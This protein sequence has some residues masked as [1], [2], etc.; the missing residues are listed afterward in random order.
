ME[1][2]AITSAEPKE[3][4]MIAKYL[5]SH[6]VIIDTEFKST[7]VLKETQAHKRRELISDVEY[8]YALALNHGDHY[9]GQAEIRF[10]V[11]QLPSDDNELFLDCAALAVADLKINNHHATEQS[12][13][14]KHVIQ[15]KATQLKKGWNKVTLR[16]LTPYNNNR[17]GLHSFI[18]Q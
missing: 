1:S 5:G 7:G 8:T 10:Y 11:E 2:T 14:N 18:D 15:L 4:E 16:Y 6:G 3:L 9:L 13:F 12:A 17:V